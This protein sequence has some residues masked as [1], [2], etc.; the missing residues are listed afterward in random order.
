P[1]AVCCVWTKASELQRLAAL[2]CTTPYATASCPAS[3]IDLQLRACCRL[4]R[5][6]E[7]Q[8]AAA[9]GGA[10]LHDPVRYSQLSG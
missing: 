9:S 3:D 10:V 6:D 1:A 2:F 4:L 8:R 5:L 7:S